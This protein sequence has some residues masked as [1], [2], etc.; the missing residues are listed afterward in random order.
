MGIGGLSRRGE[1]LSM[2]ALRQAALEAKGKKEAVHGQLLQALDHID[3]LRGQGHNL[4]LE[5]SEKS[6]VCVRAR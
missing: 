5:A 2:G 1:A 4:A 3:L 6:T